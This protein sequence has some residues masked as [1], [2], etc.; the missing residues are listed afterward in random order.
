MKNMLLRA[1]SKTDNQTE[2]CFVW[3]HRLGERKLL[4]AIKIVY[5]CMINTRF[6]ALLVGNAFF[7]G[8]FMSQQW[9]YFILGTQMILMCALH[10]HIIHGNLPKVACVGDSTFVH[11]STCTEIKGACTFK[12]LHLLSDAVLL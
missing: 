11:I 6:E 7:I 9:F 5:L 3:I 1:R 4:D 12:W 2:V 8:R 10:F